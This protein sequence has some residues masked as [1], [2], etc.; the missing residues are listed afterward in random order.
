MTLVTGAGE[1]VG[2][3]PSLYCIQRS[4]PYRTWYLN[5]NHQYSQSY[6][7]NVL[8]GLVSIPQGISCF[9]L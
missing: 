5:F 8:L 3:Q 9:V 1:V 7:P 4:A 2:K 6:L